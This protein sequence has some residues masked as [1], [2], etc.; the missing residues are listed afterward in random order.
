[1]EPLR[2][3][4]R[5]YLSQVILLKNAKQMFRFLVNH[6]LLDKEG[7]R[8]FK[9]ILKKGHDDLWR[10]Y[11]HLT[12]LHREEGKSKMYCRHDHAEIN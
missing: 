8:R 3:L 11:L 12:K 1:M 6:E 5:F 4:D 9:E 2:E 7:T 10:N